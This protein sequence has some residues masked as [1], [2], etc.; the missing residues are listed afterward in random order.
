MLCSTLFKS[1]DLEHRLVS[2]AYIETEE[3]LN[4]CGKSLMY[5][6][7]KSSLRHYPWGTPVS[8]V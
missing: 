3:V 6:T 4:A 1:F 5:N 7:N 8:I 2:S